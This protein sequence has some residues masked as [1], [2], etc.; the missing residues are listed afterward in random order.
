VKD[1][2]FYKWKNKEFVP[3]FYYEESMK[4]PFGMYESPAFK[5]TPAP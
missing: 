5:G 4:K 1:Q 3:D 2:A